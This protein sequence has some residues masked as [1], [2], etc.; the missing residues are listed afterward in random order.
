MSS[1]LKMILVKKYLF[2]TIHTELQ[3]LPPLGDLTYE[4]SLIY[5]AL[6]AIVFRFLNVPCKSGLFTFSNIF[7]PTK[8][9]LR[10]CPDW[11]AI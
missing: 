8:F 7:P 5:Q 9:P 1:R 11:N 2:G 6:V 10:V 3:F 4:W